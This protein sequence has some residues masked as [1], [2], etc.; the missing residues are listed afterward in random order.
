MKVF[1]KTLLIGQFSGCIR[2][3]NPRA[4]LDKVGMDCKNSFNFFLV[5][6]YS[7]AGSSHAQFM[8]PFPRVFL[9]GFNLARFLLIKHFRSFLLYQSFCCFVLD[10]HW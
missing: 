4:N 1:L 6:L 9:L 3:I 8:V 10:V 2:D 7:L 5:L